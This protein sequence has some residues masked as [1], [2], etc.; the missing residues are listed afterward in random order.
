MHAFRLYGLWTSPILFWGYMINKCQLVECFA[1]L[2]IRNENINFSSLLLV[3]TNWFFSV[4]LAFLSPHPSEEKWVSHCSLLLGQPEFQ[5]PF[6]DL[7][8]NSSSGHVHNKMGTSG[9]RS[10][11]RLGKR[12]WSLQQLNLTVCSTKLDCTSPRASVFRSLRARSLQNRTHS[13]LMSFVF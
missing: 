4:Y 8:L 5:N 1:S 6:K 7:L 11:Q 2:G 13:F 9:I 3:M 12:G 10:V